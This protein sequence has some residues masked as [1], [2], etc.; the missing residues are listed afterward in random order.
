M[1]G[2]PVN[3]IHAAGTRRNDWVPREGEA[4]TVSIRKGGGKSARLM[5]DG[6]F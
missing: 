4:G 1:Y 2:C 5:F 3:G 6:G